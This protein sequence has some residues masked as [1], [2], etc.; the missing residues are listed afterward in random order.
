MEC[1]DQSGMITDK[2][3]Q[4]MVAPKQLPALLLRVHSDQAVTLQQKKKW[5]HCAHSTGLLFFF[6]LVC[7]CVA[8]Q[9]R[10]RG[11]NDTKCALL[12]Y[13]KSKL[14]MFSAPFFLEGSLFDFAFSPFLLFFFI[15]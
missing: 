8:L 10:N 3:N 5:K 11:F 4:K 13:E 9:R 7:V 15:V 14:K 2:W 1:Y 12:F 6:F